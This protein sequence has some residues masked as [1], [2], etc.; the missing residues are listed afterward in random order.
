MIK[1]ILE[2]KRDYKIILQNGPRTG[3]YNQETGKEIINF[4]MLRIVEKYDYLKL[5]LKVLKLYNLFTKPIL[6][7]TS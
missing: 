2:D 4:D 5:I 6:Y 1:K 3:K 7:L